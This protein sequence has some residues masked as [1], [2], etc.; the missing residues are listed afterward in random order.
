[1]TVTEEPVRTGTE[2][3]TCTGSRGLPYLVAYSGDA[4]TV[5]VVARDDGVS[6]VHADLVHFVAVDS[7]PPTDSWVTVEM[8]WTFYCP[9]TACSY[10]SPHIVC[11]V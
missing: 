3:T 4:T 6:K 1:M 7:D 11:E 2:G 9:G 8:E 5:M 10:D